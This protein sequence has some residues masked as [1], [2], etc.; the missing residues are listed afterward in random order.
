[1]YPEHPA[2]AG[3]DFAAGITTARYRKKSPLGTHF[4]HCQINDLAGQKW[5]PEEITTGRDFFVVIGGGQFTTKDGQ[6]TTPAGSRSRTQPSRLGFTLARQ[7]RSASSCG[8]P[9]AATANCQPAWASL[10]TCLVEVLVD[11]CAR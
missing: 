8:P 9:C 10:Q 5:H 2:C 4:R 7:R 1:M 11:G 6:A 3:G